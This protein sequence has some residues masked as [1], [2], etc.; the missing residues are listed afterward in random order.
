MTILKDISILWSLLHTL[1]MFSLLFESRYP[2]KKAI[3]LTLSTMLP[4]LIANFL[5]YLLA[6]NLK[7][8]VLLATCVLPSLIFFWFI[9]KYR[10]GRFLFTFCLSDTIWLEVMYITNILDFYLGNQYIFMFVSRLLAYPL[11][12]LLFLKVVRPIYLDVQQSVKNG[13]YTFSAISGI[14]Y[15]MMLLSMSYPTMI[16]QRPEYLPAFALQL[17]LLPVV[18]IHMFTTLRRQKQL[19]TVSEQ[20]NILQLQVISM[21]S[22]IEEF[23][24]ANELFREERHNFRHTM[25]TVAALAEKGQ[26]E[27][28]HAMAQEY[29]DSLPEKPVESYC[30][31]AVLD[32]VLSSYLQRAKRKDIRVSAKISFPTPLPVN[33]SELATVFANAIENAIHACEK[34][35][36]AERYI[37]VKVLSEPCFMLQVKNSFDGIVAFDGDDIPI[38]PRKGHGFG[39]RSIV[40]FCEKNDAFYEFKAEEDVFYLRLIFR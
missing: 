29:A 24:A 22:R 37:E 15:V 10:D 5:L 34:I 17:V 16:M 13:W 28:L 11:L 1:V 31:H 21:R 6:D 35:E 38:S 40:T 33:E 27:Q 32:A 23:S 26:Y 25:R 14:F 4:L 3:F 12:D 2:R 7:Y 39:T 8:M 19:Y 9:A 30:N 18:Y 36:A 20:E